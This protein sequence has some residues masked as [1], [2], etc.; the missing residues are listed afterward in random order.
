MKGLQHQTPPLSGLPAL[1]EQQGFHN[2]AAP[3]HVGGWLRGAAHE[4]LLVEALL[5]EQ[6]LRTVPAGLPG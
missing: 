3:S 1:P 5:A 2:A 6:D 4:E